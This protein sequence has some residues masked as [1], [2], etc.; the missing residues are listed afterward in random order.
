VVRDLRSELQKRREEGDKDYREVRRLQG[1]VRKQQDQENAYQERL[2][3]A[4]A[5]VELYKRLASEAIRREHEAR[6]V[7]S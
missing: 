1:I 4:D 5:E 7:A 3:D 2:R 6:A